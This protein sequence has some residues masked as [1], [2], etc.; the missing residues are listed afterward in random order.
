MPISQ[1][2]GLIGAGRIRVGLADMQNV[3]EIAHELHE[4]GVGSGNLAGVVQQAFDASLSAGH[5][6]GTQRGMACQVVKLPEIE[7]AVIQA[8]FAGRA[9]QHGVQ[10]GTAF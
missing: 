8:E 7:I 4:A 6:Q 9:R 2:K 1:Y 5:A 3:A 10:C